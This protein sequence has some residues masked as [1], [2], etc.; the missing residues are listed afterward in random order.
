MPTTHKVGGRLELTM[1]AISLEYFQSN[2]HCLF[3]VVV[4][5]DPQTL[6]LVLGNGHQQVTVRA[7]VPK[8]LLDFVSQDEIYSV[9][10][11]LR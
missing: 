2:R 11:K 8:T 9:L 7:S 1:R 3:S 5:T 4:A 10:S 6:S